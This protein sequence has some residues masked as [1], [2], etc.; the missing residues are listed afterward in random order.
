[1]QRL[2]ALPGTVAR[3]EG[4]VRQRLNRPACRS[5]LCLGVR[6]GLGACAGL[7]DRLR[8]SQ[9]H[10]VGLDLGVCPEVGL[11]NRQRR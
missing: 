10:G 8:C 6:G 9:R 4:G 11:V 5:D 7:L 2:Q 1:M 3:P